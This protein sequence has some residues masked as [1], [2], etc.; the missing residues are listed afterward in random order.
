MSESLSLTTNC[1]HIELLVPKYLILSF[2][3]LLPPTLHPL[4]DHVVYISHVYPETV[5][6]SFSTTSLGRVS[7]LLKNSFIT[8]I[9]AF[10]IYPLVIH[11]LQRSFTLIFSKSPVVSCHTW[12]QMHP[13]SLRLQ[14]PKWS[15]L[16][17]DSSSGT[18]PLS[19]K[20]MS[21]T[22]VFLLFFHCT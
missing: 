14:C 13:P 4:V 9:S 16:T 17:G 7:L 1:L 3:F 10:T 18:S 12:T 6:F 5:L 21:V 19:T 8:T 2:L 22:L 11:L 20:Y 15:M